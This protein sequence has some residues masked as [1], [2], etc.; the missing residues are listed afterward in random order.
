MTPSDAIIET[1]ALTRRFGALTAVDRV[2]LRVRRGEIFGC[3]GPNGSGKSTLMRMLL[4]LLAPSAGDARVLGCVIPNDAEHLRPRVGYMTQRFSLY[5]DLSVDENLDF[6]AEIFGMARRQRRQRVAAA[7]ADAG[8]ERYRATR[9]AA[10]SGGWKQ[11]LAL[12]AATIHDPELLLLDEPTAGVDPQSRR[13][14]WEKL[15]DLAARGTTIVVSTHYMDE[16]VRCHRLCMLRDGQRV[17]MGAPRQLT[18]ALTG[19]VVDLHTAQTD[20]AIS[21]LVTSPLVASVTQLGDTAHVL[22]VAAAPAAPASALELRAM[23]TAGGIPV[24]D[25]GPSQPTLEDV[26]VAILLGERFEHGDADG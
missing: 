19:R 24:T 14:F 17:A 20:T 25:A 6:A 12:A 7:I 22:L 9:A 16:A 21:R 2:D 3:L 10:L 15:F 11:R 23:L 8:M 18:A 13:R 5:D 26:F 4:G 1:R